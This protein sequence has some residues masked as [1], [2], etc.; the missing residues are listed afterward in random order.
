[1]ILF[2]EKTIKEHKS[3]QI[4]LIILIKL[5]SKQKTEK[6]GVACEYLYRAKE[7]DRLPDNISD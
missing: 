4:I 7:A 1:M 5:T 2:E 3:K 6:K